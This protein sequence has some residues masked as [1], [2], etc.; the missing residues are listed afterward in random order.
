M[1]RHRPGEPDCECQHAEHH[2][3]QKPRHQQ[4]LYGGRN[5]PKPRKLH[6]KPV[7]PSHHRRHFHLWIPG[8]RHW[9]HIEPMGERELG[10]GHRV[11]H[12]GPEVPRQ[13]LPHGWPRMHITPAPH[14]L[15][16]APPAP[17]PTHSGR[18]RIVPATTKEKPGHW[19]W[20]GAL[21]KHVWVGHH[22]NEQIDLSKIPEPMRTGLVG[23]MKAHSNKWAH[24]HTLW[25]VAGGRSALIPGHWA[26][27]RH[28]GEWS[29]V[30]QHIDRLGGPARGT[31]R[32][33]V[34][35]APPGAFGPRPAHLP[36]LHFWPDEAGIMRD[37]QNR[38]PSDGQTTIHVP[39][40]AVFARAHQLLSTAWA[41]KIGAMYGQGMED[42]LA[43]RTL[44]RSRRQLAYG[45]RQP[46]RNVPPEVAR[47]ERL[48][49][50]MH[51]Q[52]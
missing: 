11:R 43:A 21:G 19:G 36:P 35:N 30:E 24:A 40:H 34:S 47:R 6:V 33:H 22:A 25:G 46:G 45:A 8:A 42:A 23:L 10:P 2:E 9:A 41:N 27:N 39:A 29:Y 5:R 31:T 37:Q 26:H 15:H 18:H 51:S 1:H 3:R 13:L 14:H 28:T 38:T 7:K 32:Y 20:S 48:Y 50:Q 17:P 44:Q 4:H 49:A 16:H 12:H 52:A